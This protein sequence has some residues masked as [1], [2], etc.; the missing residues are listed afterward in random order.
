ML[1][2]TCLEKLS[3]KMDQSCLFCSQDPE[4][5]VCTS[6]AWSEASTQKVSGTQDLAGTPQTALVHS[7][8]LAWT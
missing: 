3:G 1:S 8:L 2:P 6:L 4:P 5:A 7:N